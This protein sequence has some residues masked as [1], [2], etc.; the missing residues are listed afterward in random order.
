MAAVGRESSFMP[1]VKCSTCG[2]QVEISLMGEH[3][4]AGSSVPDSTP[5][6]P[7]ASIFGRLLP[8]FG[9][10]TA[11]KQQPRAPPQVDTNAANR[12]YAGQGDLT[13]IS[14]S[15]GSQNSISPQTPDVR[16]GAGKGDDY[17]NPKI[18]DSSHSPAQ[19]R[20]PGGY[21]GLEADEGP[22]P[23]PLTETKPAPSPMDQLNT[24]SPAVFDTS[25]RPSAPALTGPTGYGGLGPGPDAP[26][27]P[28]RAET[29]PRPSDGFAPPPR[30]P[31]APPL[32][33]T[34]RPDDADGRMI[35][36]KARRPS[37][38]PETPRA[39][40]PRTALLR[41]K[42]PLA[43][44][45]NLAE[46]FGVGNPYHNPSESTSSENS[47]EF[48]RRPSQASHVSTASSRTSPP[49]SLSSRSGKNSFDNL[50]A[51]I[52]ASMDDMKAKPP[53][54]KIP[55]RDPR[56]NRP[57]PLSAR[58]PRTGERGY[59]PRIDP[60]V[61]NPRFGRGKPPLA[62]PSVNIPTEEERLGLQPNREPPTPASATLPSPPYTISPE[63]FGSDR[64]RQQPQPQPPQTRDPD[65][66]H[67]TLDPRDPF[68]PTPSSAAN[69]TPTQI[70]TS[71]QPP[72]ALPSARGNC[73]AC[74]QPIRGKS[75]SSADG[76]LTG[77]YHKPCFV[78]TTCRAPFTSS[79]F[80]VLDDRPY[81]ELHYH[82][83][84][85]SLCG[86]CGRGIEGQYLEDERAVKHH[87]G[88][89]RCARCGMALRN[90][91]FEVAGKAY[92]EDD[93]WRLVEMQAQRE[94]GGMGWGGPGMGGG[95]GGGGG[96]M[97]PGP[98][99][100]PG[101][102]RGF[103]PGGGRGGGYGG[104]GGRFGPGPLGPPGPRPRMEK[105]MTRLGMM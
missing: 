43:P 68:P 9:S 29:F 33:A 47:S 74:Q 39:P 20:R 49:R 1:T 12:A 55:P 3:K 8:S 19:P 37:R 103:P 56:D 11:Q 96:G 5:P 62:S 51:D 83:L 101:G 4:C 72:S 78:C 84:N 10:S 98:Q 65:P 52:Q 67:S 59:D 31:S 90:G 104:P 70:P 89:F 30:T 82:E 26:P 64:P 42:T 63:P 58:P 69:P 95:R 86:S 6:I 102:P 25:R 15:S 40:P 81:C 105:R 34:S 13:P 17:F 77:R 93:A 35:T 94:Q 87:V 60:A 73:K 53:P 21:G 32:S 85:G 24:L 22:S 7:A 14:L 88:C 44:T 27:T 100:L 50:M 71:A 46:E 18:A 61:Q 38:G 66:P 48:E 75:I 45:I 57:S 99:G 80:Y 2:Q 28:S 79:T 97:R 76:R 23:P 36:D 91:Y 16:P 54:L 41:P 92:C